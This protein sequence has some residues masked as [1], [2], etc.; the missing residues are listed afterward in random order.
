M[1]ATICRSLRYLTAALVLSLPGIAVAQNVIVDGDLT[2]LIAHAQADQADRESDVTD[3]F[4]SG[5]DFTHV[6][7]YYNPKR[8]TL[9][10]GIQLQPNGAFP[11]VPGDADGDRNPNAKSRLDIPQDQFGVGMD[12]AYIVSIDTNVD[13]NFDGPDDTTFL[14]RSNVQRLLRGDGSAPHAGM[15]TEIAL[16]V[17]GAISDPGMPNQ[18][19]NTDNIEIA[20]RN[21]SFGFAGN[22]TGGNPC[23]FGLCVFAGS[24]VD[25]LKE[26]Q[27]DSELFFS[28]PSNVTFSNEFS[29]GSGD[30]SCVAA[31][32]GA[33]LTISA[34]IHNTTTDTLGPIWINHQ[35]PDGL[36]YVAGS[37]SG[38]VE[39]RSARLQNGVLVRHLRPGFDN[40]LDPNETETITF[41]IRVV[42]VPS[43]P[44]L[45][46]GY[47]EGVFEPVGGG[48]KMCVFSC[49]DVLCVSQSGT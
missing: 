14:Y 25:S 9:Y 23:E 5:W 48:S 30:D 39:G 46:R 4:V 28:F 36:E 2:D 43:T 33:I 22:D 29:P 47:A 7:V 35:I 21:F 11:G 17:R 13:A 19:L 27:L 42:S 1:K 41:Q 3:A 37:I 40:T 31:S 45:I 49:L 8:D 18:N 15:T 44:L 6:Y 38:A 32:P 16:G 24:L 10:V 26:D 20:I 34:T 12:E